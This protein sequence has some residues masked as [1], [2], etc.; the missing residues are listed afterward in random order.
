VDKRALSKGAFIVLAG[1]VLILCGRYFGS[2]DLLAARDTVSSLRDQVARLKSELRSLN[3]EQVMLKQSAAVD[4]QAY[5]AVERDLRG[6][7]D[8]IAELRKEI[9]FYRAM[10]NVGEQS[11]GL[12]IQSFQIRGSKQLPEVSYRLILT[13]YMNS[14]RTIGGRIEMQVEG[15][16]GD[17]PMSVGPEHL[18]LSGA[19]R[20]RFRFKYFQELTGVMILPEGF[21]PAR[22]QIRARLDDKKRTFVERAFPWDEVFRR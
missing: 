18:K 8:E 11:P 3:Q 1:I 19:S 7:Q 4:R 13:Q 17:S 12:H 9:A 15:M 14:N 10:V 16:Q 5:D 22:I 20:T 6:Q 21:L 2:Y